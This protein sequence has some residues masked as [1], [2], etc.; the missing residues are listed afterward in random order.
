MFL[1]SASAHGHCWRQVPGED[2]AHPRKSQQDSTQV[3][4]ISMYTHL[5]QEERKIKL[6]ALKNFNI[7]FYSQN[8]KAPKEKE[9]IL[10]T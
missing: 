10:L 7:E 8:N 3:T 4:C 2:S 9:A 6:F 1:L 5:V